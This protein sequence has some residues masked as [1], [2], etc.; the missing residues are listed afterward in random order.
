MVIPHFF[1]ST[2]KLGIICQ[3]LSTKA[4]T[5]LPLLAKSLPTDCSFQ[6]DYISL[7]LIPGFA[8]GILWPM[9]HLYK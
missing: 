6:G 7:P 2:N 9:K 5:L 4:M 8:V 3:N 1:Q